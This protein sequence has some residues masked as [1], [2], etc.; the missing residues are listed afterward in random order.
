MAMP[1]EE[2]SA[3]LNAGPG[4]GS[5]VAVAA[6]WREL[7]SHYIRAAT[8]L[9]QLLVELQASSWQ[10]TSGRQYLAAHGPYLAWL[11]Q[12]AIDSAVTAARHE[13]AVAA[14]WSA[15]AAMPTLTELATNHAVHDLFVATNFFGI[16]G[17]PIAVNEAEYLRMWVQAADTMA[18]YQAVTENAMSATHAQPAPPIL[19]PGGETTRGALPH[20]PSP[21]AELLRHIA[22]FIAHPYRYFAEFFERLGLSPA[23]VVALAVIALFMY[24]VLWY[25]Y[26]A[27][28]SLL[29]LPFFAPALSALGALGVLMP[30]PKGPSARPLPGLAES[31]IGREESATM[32]VGLALATATGGE[33]SQFSSPTPTTSTSP[34]VSGPPSAT[35]I[36]YAVP[37]LSPPGERFGPKA[38]S[39]LDEIAAETLGTTAL[40]FVPPLARRKQHG[41][42]DAAARGF[43]DELPAATGRLGDTADALA[44]A[45]LTS[46]AT[47]NERAGRIGL[48]GTAPIPAIIPAGMVERWSER[49]SKGVPLLPA[50]WAAD[51]DEKPGATWENF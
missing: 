42:I 46:H 45:E 2:H 26:Y 51:A 36:S 34:P 24:D 21:V 47:S 29:L 28:Y 23:T 11:E 44:S 37:G 25:P 17:I 27:S 33:A 39:S 38:S 30:W 8:D 9:S 43:R 1:P 31:N 7:S 19:A 50:T 3:G 18:T 16:N 48:P 10:G 4:P 6:K 40:A 14:Y 20:R 32:N 22:D 12:A 35:A 49:T 15:V 13:S 5:L 41:K